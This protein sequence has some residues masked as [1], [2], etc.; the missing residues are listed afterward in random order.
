MHSPNGPKAGRVDDMI[1][2]E[3]L[4]LVFFITSY[5]S[6]DQLLRLVRVLRKSEP[7]SPIVIHHDRWKSDI[8]LG[9]FEQYPDVHV[10]TS[11]EPIEWGD[12]SLDL[13][14][15]R[16]FRWI[17]TNLDADWV[18][19]LSEQDYPIKPLGALRT[20]LAS[21]KV[22]AYI[23]GQP[24]DALEN[25]ELRAHCEI[26]YLYQF[27]TLPTVKAASRL[28]AGLKQVGY[29]SRNAVA[30][31]LNR[32][33]RLLFVDLRPR[34]LQLPSRIGRRVKNPPFGESFPCWY[35]DPWFS[36]SREAMEYL[37]GFVDSHPDLI[38]YYGRTVV[39]LESVSGTIICNNP[40]LRVE[41]ES[42]HET[43][44]SNAASGRPDVYRLADLA[45]LQSSSAVFAR[46]FD[47]G[48]SDLM[49]ELDKIVLQSSSHDP[50]ESEKD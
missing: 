29:K 47:Q 39:P 32:Y 43:R 24:I 9:P 10:L 34:E 14:R 36:I 3:E 13:A 17:M 27:A 38:K 23:E 20:K 7:E 26:R 1:G 28:P 12:L 6:P 19:L 48:S 33:Q 46:K 2:P 37:V 11:E 40:D 42:L 41:N 45:F 50:R 25:E 35:H 5:R 49:D 30:Y 21:N 31:G 4:R 16:V 8:D 15:W 44:W 22:D 18:I